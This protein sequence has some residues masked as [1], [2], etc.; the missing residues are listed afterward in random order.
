MS[1]CDDGNEVCSVS[2]CVLMVMRCVV[3]ECVC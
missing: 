2:E 3:S 1:V